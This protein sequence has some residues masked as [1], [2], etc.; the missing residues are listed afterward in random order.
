V[1]LEIIVVMIMRAERVIPARVKVLVVTLP[2][3]RTLVFVRRVLMEIVVV[4]VGAGHVN[5]MVVF[6]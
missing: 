4:V 1:L 3:T 2:Q 6:V 5:V